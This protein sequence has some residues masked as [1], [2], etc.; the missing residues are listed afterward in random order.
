MT[1]L[2]PATDVDPQY[3]AWVAEWLGLD[4]ARRQ[5]AFL[6]RLEE[7]GIDPQYEACLADRRA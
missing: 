7:E 2:Y 6:Q 1:Q 5:E 4:E 3:E